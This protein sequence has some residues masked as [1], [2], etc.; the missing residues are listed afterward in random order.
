MGLFSKPDS[1]AMA[2]YRKA[3]RDLDDNDRE[4]QRRGI[5]HET[6]EFL[7]LNEAVIEAEKKVPWWRR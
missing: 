6:D 1:E 4:E 2:A 3:R 7:R 5:R